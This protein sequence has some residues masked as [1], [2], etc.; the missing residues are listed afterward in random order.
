MTARKEKK[1]KVIDA[2]ESEVILR[3]SDM[4]PRAAAAA[5]LTLPEE[6]A[7]LP[8]R[9]MVIFPGMVVPLMVGREK[10]HRL[11]DAVLP[12]QK[13]IV[14]V[15]Q[16]QA[17]TEDPTSDDL[18]AVGTAVMVL[19]LLRGEDNTQTIIVHGMVRVKAERYLTSEPY[20]RAQIAP[21]ADTV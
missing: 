17:E 13:V 6:A 15:C 3:A 5:E 18:H 2:D 11:I 14:T 9:N 20:F 4:K 10:S 7:V 8:L 19:K 21:L 12:H 1:R 16:K